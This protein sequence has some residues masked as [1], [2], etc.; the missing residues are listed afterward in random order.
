MNGIEEKVIITQVYLNIEFLG[1]FILESKNRPNLTVEK[2]FEEWQNKIKWDKPGEK[3]RLLNQGIILTSLWGLIVY[4]REK[5]DQRIDRLQERLEDWGIEEKDLT[6][7]PPEDK[8][9]KG[10]I[11]HMRNSI[12]H[13]RVS[14]NEH[15]S[16]IFRDGKRNKGAFDENF[17]IELDVRKIQK[18][19]ETFVGYI[20]E[21]KGRKV[22]IN[23]SSKF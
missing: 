15:L 19:V 9:L 7:C 2:F 6:K 18:F 3:Y 22:R 12:S 17:V 23:S 4:P 11:R 20:L 16:F 5:F 8:N 10:V 21:E 1:S 13:G 14:V